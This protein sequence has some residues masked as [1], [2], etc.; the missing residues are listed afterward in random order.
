MPL[1]EYVC[2]HCGHAFEI[3]QKMGE[4]GEK[5]RCA[6]CGEVG[7]DRQLSTFAGHTG[8]ATAAA[9]SAAPG[10]GAGGGFT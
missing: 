4:G 5:L 8:A 1:Y 6:A 9:S 2:R 10:C 3:L 7:A